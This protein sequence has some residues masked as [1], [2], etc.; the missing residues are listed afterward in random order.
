MSSKNSHASKNPV[1]PVYDAS[2]VKFPRLH[3]RRAAESFWSLQ[4]TKRKMEAEPQKNGVK[5]LDPPRV[6][7][8]SPQVCFWWLK[9]LK[10]QTLG[11]FR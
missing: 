10:F 7:N 4:I 6:S 11:G 2:S 9:G 5:T 3:E 1:S 8:F